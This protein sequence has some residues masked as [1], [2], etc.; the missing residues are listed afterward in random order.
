MVWALGSEETAECGSATDL[1]LVDV[2]GLDTDGRE[3]RLV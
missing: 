3:S 2:L 1:L